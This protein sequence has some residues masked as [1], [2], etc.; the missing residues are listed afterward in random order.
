[1]TK[2]RVLIVEDYEPFSR[3]LQCLLKEEPALQLEAFAS[4]GM[5]ALHAAEDLHPDLI[6]LDIDLPKLTGIEVARRLRDLETASTI[7]FVTN[8]LS[9]GLVD[10][11][12]ALGARGYVLKTDVVPELPIA[13][14]TVLNGGTF[15]SSSCRAAAI[16][17]GPNRMAHS[18][19][20]VGF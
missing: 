19:A 7:I 20:A 2:T 12:F 15:I 17:M 10:C 6:L 16:S 13:I 8:E 1:M 9:P 18:A 3:L 5:A 11:A 4:D 14:K